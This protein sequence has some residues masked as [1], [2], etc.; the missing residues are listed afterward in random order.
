M[1]A[2]L[3]HA[4]FEAVMMQRGWLARQPIHLPRLAQCVCNDSSNSNTL[5]KHH[6]KT[7]GGKCFW[8]VQW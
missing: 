8:S 7:L 4:P 6:M 1:S 2:I 5:C 3:G